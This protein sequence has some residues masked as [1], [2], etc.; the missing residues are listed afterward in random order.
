[1]KREKTSTAKRQVNRCE[2]GKK[3]KQ[4]KRKCLLQSG[5]LCHSTVASEALKF[6][7]GNEQKIKKKDTQMP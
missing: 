2:I 3:K 5:Y 7:K 4:N 1:M 6:N